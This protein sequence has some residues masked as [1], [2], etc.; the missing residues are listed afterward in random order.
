MNFHVTSLN[1]GRWTRVFYVNHVRQR[2]MRVL[3]SGRFRAV[4]GHSSFSE[5]LDSWIRT[6]RRRFFEPFLEGS[7]G[8]LLL[9]PSAIPSSTGRTA[10]PVGQNRPEQ[11]HPNKQFF[12]HLGKGSCGVPSK[13]HL[14]QAIQRAHRIGQTRPVKAEA[15]FTRAKLPICGACTRRDV[16]LFSDPQ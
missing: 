4:W 5:P 13:R 1:K 15:A 2:I 6:L 3:C 9:R 14:N 7:G 10:S 11:G 16:C 8:C 12:T